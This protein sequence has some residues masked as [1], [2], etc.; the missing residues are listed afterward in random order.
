M[1]S[2][3]QEFKTFAA[4]GS[5]IDMAVGIII[6]S[7]FGA[8][9]RSLVDDVLMPPLGL[10]LGNADFADLFW[11]LSAGDPAGPYPTL[12]DAQA[13]GA[14]TLN[15]GGF[16]NT[17]ISFILIAFAMF[18]LI[19]YINRIQTAPETEEPTAPTTRKCPYCISV[20]SISATR[21]P[22]CTSELETEEA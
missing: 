14:V 15:Y 3:W 16:V 20:V 22:H 12:A 9:A 21:C 5:V 2:L 6:G 11:T 7:A 1:S 8:I 13:A 4:R 10:L 17:I 19:R 18:L